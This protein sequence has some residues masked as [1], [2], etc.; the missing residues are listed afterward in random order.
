MTKMAYDAIARPGRER[1]Q[2]TG[3]RF[4]TDLDHLFA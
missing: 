1:D 3:E 2:R 4:E